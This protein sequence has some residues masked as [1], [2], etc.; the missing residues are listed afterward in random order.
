LQNGLDHTFL[1]RNRLPVDHRLCQAEAGLVVAARRAFEELG[2]GGGRATERRMRDR[3][4]R[5]GIEQFHRVGIGAQR[6]HGGVIHLIKVIEQSEPRCAGRS[7]DASASLDNEVSEDLLRCNTSRNVIH[8]A[9]W[10][11]T[12]KSMLFSDA[13]V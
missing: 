13:S 4:E 3:V 11:E 7:R 10:A 1:D 5:I 2:G 8:A 6:L 12:R 9:A